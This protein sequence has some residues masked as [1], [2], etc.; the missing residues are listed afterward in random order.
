MDF[1][2][3]QEKARTTKIYPTIKQLVV[4]AMRRAGHDDSADALE[5]MRLPDVDCNPYHAALGLGETGEIQ[6]KV[7]KINRDDNGLISEERRQAIA[8]E[9]GDLLW[10]VAIMCDE[11]NLDMQA[12]AEGN[13]QVLESRQKRGTLKGDG[14]NR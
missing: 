7:K 13:I 8:Q 2:E 1:R 9:L 12:V 10:Y 5:N 3:Y 14:D 6:N 11:L 4:S